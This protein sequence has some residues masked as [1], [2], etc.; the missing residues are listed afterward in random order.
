M[1]HGHTLTKQQAAS[2]NSPNDK[3]NVLS[4]VE[5]KIT[6]CPTYF[7]ARSAPSAISRR[8]GNM[9]VGKSGIAMK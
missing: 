2:A 9:K 4:S 1:G 5:T 3:P 8:T 7:V 6:C